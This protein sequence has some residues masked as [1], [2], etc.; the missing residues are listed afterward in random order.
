MRFIRNRA[1]IKRGFFRLP[2]VSEQA[3]DNVHHKIKYAP[4]S[5]VFNLRYVFKL[6]IHR[7]NQDP[8]SKQY[9]IY[10]RH[11]SVFHIFP[12]FRYQSDTAAEERIKKFLGN[13][14]PV[15]EKPA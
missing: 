8:F 5:G 13:I 9:F 7:F 6:I 11:Q 15:S 4:M 14:S 3:G 1:E 2:G 10:D 12:D